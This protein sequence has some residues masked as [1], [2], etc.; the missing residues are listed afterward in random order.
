MLVSLQKVTDAFS[1]VEFNGTASLS[2]TKP[3]PLIVTEVPRHNFA[4]GIRDK[5]R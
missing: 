5:S 2:P 3:R 4:S 1:P